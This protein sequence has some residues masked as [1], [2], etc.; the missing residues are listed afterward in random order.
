MSTRPPFVLV[1]NPAISLVY[2]KFAYTVDS[3][4]YQN[5]GRY[6]F[7][8]SNFL[9]SLIILIKS[10]SRVIMHDNKLD[11]AILDTVYNI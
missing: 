1:I 5:L 8:K 10:L 7:R 4:R 2:Y 11:Q 3:V 6:S 9:F